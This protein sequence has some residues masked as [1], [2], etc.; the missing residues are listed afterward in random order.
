MKTSSNKPAYSPTKNAH[1][2]KPLKKSYKIK[3]IKQPDS[4]FAINNKDKA[5]I[6]R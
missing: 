5:E 6:L 3:T 1:C 4:S 2:G